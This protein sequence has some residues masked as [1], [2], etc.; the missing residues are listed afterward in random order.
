MRRSPPST[1]RPP[2]TPGDQLRFHV[3]AQFVL[4]RQADHLPYAK[5]LNAA[6]LGSSA[7]TSTASPAGRRR[8]TS[9]AGSPAA[10]PTPA[11]PQQLHTA[12]GGGKS[13]P[14]YFTID[15][16]I[17]RDTWN[18]LAV[19]WF[20]GI[21]SVLGVQRT[22]IYGGIK[23]C[24]WAADDGVIGNSK[25]AGA[26]VDLADPVLVGRQN[27]SRCGA[28]PTRGEY[29]VES[30]PGGRRIRSRR[31][32]RPRPGRRSVEPTSVMA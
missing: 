3:T 23:P 20:R 27:P 14:I 7:T 25:H 19:R 21:N 13:A 31:Q 1:F 6:G 9:P 29:R 4:R 22:G 24:Q 30:G 17:N 8:R 15:D 5:S 32:R 11:P 16:D 2:A 26:A 18:N 12:A 10:S 28:L